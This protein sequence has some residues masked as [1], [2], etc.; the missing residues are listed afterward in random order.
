MIDVWWWSSQGIWVLSRLVKYLATLTY[1]LNFLLIC[2]SDG[3]LFFSFFSFSLTD[4]GNN[5]EKNVKSGVLFTSAI[6]IRRHCSHARQIR[7]P[8]E[9]ISNGFQEDGRSSHWSES[10]LSFFLRSCVCFG[11]LLH[12]TWYVS[13]DGHLDRNNYASPCAR[14][15]IVHSVPLLLVAHACRVPLYGDIRRPS[16]CDAPLNMLHPLLRTQ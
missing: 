5:L 16:V 1:T 10:H 11:V 7:F 14:S 2:T 12:F 6:T 3:V 8:V 13:T 4:L 9:L 15:Q